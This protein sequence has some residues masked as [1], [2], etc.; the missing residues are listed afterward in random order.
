MIRLLHILFWLLLLPTYPYAADG[1]QISEIAEQFVIRQLSGT[2]GEKKVS[3]GY[4]DASRLPDCQSHDAFLPPG[5]RLVSRA[6][7]GVRCNHPHRWSVLVPV[8]ISIIGNYLTLNRALGAGQVIHESDL[9]VN[10]GDISNL[11]TGAIADIGVAVGKQLRNS[12]GAGQVLRAD[13]LLSPWIIRQG[14]PV[15]VISQG[16]GFSITSEGLAL[17]NVAAGQVAQ[18]RMPSGQTLSGIVQKDG[19]VMIPF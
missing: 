1:K 8:Q 14:Q 6:Y 17:N 13:Q 11:P 19:T 4:V 18:I 16:P 15:K 12:L 3:A 2:R 7:V 9:L 10:E 5:T